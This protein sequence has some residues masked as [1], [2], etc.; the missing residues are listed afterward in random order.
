MLVRA[1]GPVGD[2]SRLSD[3]VKGAPTRYGDPYDRGQM[4]ARVI[5]SRTGTRTT[6][7]KLAAQIRR[8]SRRWMQTRKELQ[9]RLEYR[10]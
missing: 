2:T 1:Q 8:Q 5:D 3:C 9:E 6:A 10:Q 4:D 7:S